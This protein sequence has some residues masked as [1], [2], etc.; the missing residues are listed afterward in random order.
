MNYY[1]PTRVIFKKSIIEDI[2]VVDKTLIIISNSVEKTGVSKLIKDANP[3][4]EIYVYVG[5]KQDPDDEAIID[6]ISKYRHLDIKM[7]I[8]IGGGSVLDTAKVVACLLDNDDDLND[9]FN[10]KKFKRNLKLALVP[11]TAGTASE[12]TSVS[13]IAQNKQ[14]KSFVQD[15]LYP[16]VAYVDPSLTYSMPPR[17]IANTGMDAFAHAIESYWNKNGNPISDIM[18]IKSLKLII[19]NIEKSFN[20]DLDAKDEMMFASLLAG[21]AFSQTMTTSAHA[22]SYSLSKRFEL[23]HGEACAISLPSFIRLA[24]N[25]K[26]ATLVKELGFNSLDE[27]A[28]KVTSLL[29]NL[30]MPT[31][32]ALS[33]AMRRDILV[34]KKMYQGRYDLFPNDLSDDVLYNV[35]KDISE[36]DL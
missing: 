6:I 32:L 8:G 7:V 28:S 17:V 23:R 10:G 5:V 3:D 20:G 2:E 25:E 34:E 15:E 31:K 18:A 33:E 9:Y 14:K 35:L 24:E 13:V 16:D 12:V 11:T 21:Y 30:K 4:K 22:L 29:T 27:L 19:E 36:E 1:L 26:M